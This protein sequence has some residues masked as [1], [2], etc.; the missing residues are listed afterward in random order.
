[1]TESVAPL[2]EVHG[3]VATQFGRVREVFAELSG[4][5]GSGGAAFAAVLDGRVVVDLWAGSTGA[6]PWAR[7]TR[8]VIMSST[9]GV[10]TV[11]VACLVEDG[12]IDVEAPVATYWPGFAANGKSEITV[13]TLLSHS[14]GLVTFPGY[15]EMLTP[16]GT[17]WDRTA[18]I[19]ACLEGAAPTWEPGAASGYHGVTFGW[20]VGELVRQVSGKTI[21]RLI[22]ER[23][24]EPLEIELDLGTPSERQSLVAPTILPPEP[25]PAM[26]TPDPDLFERMMFTVE[27]RNLL[28]TADQFFAAPG[29][30]GLELGAQ[31]GTATARALAVLYGALANEGSYG[32]DRPLL[33]PDVIREFTRE[34]VRGTD[35]L[36]G[37]E[38]RWGLG[39][40]LASVPHIATWH[41]REGWFGH[42]GF[43][44]QMAFADPRQRL[45]LGFVRSHLAW[46]QSLGPALV[47]AVYS[48]LPTREE[49]ESPIR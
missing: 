42:D 2:S 9:K 6:H 24:V 18:E 4:E 48:C 1:M 10:A 45:G 47:D 35:R 8:A 40:Q 25:P 7:D 39:F 44:G 17:G 13:A 14:A 37:V 29:I 28:H 19:I 26:A 23:I 46:A 21:G 33:S 11:A 30:L 43:G 5:I 31:N 32:A 38:R 36:L 15:E 20:L 22:A 27:G 12:L 41:A 34:R 3:E 16:Y 49:P